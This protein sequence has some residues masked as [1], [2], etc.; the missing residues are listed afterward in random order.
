MFPD[1]SP[2]FPK[3]AAGICI[4]AAFLITG[5]Q[6]RAEDGIRQTADREQAFTMSWENDIFA[7][8]DDNY[9]NGVRFAYLSAEDD[10]PRWLRRTSRAMPFFARDGHTRWHAAVGQSMFTPTDITVR[11]AQPEERPYAGWLYGSVGV[12]S[13]TGNRL[14]NLQLTLGVVG[15]AS[16]AEETQEAVHDFI[17]ADDPSGWDNQLENEPGI[18]LTYE[19]K[20][21]NDVF[22]FPGTSWGLDFSPTIGGSLGNIYTHAAVGGVLRFGQDLPSDYGPPLISP[23]LPGSDFFVPTSKFGWYVFTGLEGRA[24]ARNIFLDGNTFENSPSVDKYP[25][26]GG[27]QVGIAFTFDDIRV[28]YTHVFRTREYQNQPENDAFGAF[29]VSYRF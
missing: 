29:T 27:A 19:R 3:L 8:A 4:S 10:I 13:D 17:G 2:T 28:A 20:W 23:N 5:A 24:V 26:V 6:A 18:I 12:V 16:G 21:R 9:T 7:G 22:T 15:P 11:E 1:S 14:D 25:L